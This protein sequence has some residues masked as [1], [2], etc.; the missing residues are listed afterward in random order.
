MKKSI[1]LLAL[2]CINQIF[3]AASSELADKLA[4][5]RAGEI[6]VLE[7]VRK[8]INE[9][10]TTPEELKLQTAVSLANSLAIEYGLEMAEAEALRA[11]L[12]DDSLNTLRANAIFRVKPEEATP[13]QRAKAK[14]LLSQSKHRKII[15]VDR[16]A[17]NK[18]S[19]ALW[20]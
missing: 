6:E 19:I 11:L 12:T 5:S 16:D 2:C 7:A 20:G 17:A 14:G 18:W 15:G 3:G 9:K 8:A 1:L 4:R 10:Y 13:L